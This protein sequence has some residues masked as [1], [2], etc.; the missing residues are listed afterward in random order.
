MKNIGRSALML[1]ATAAMLGCTETRF[2]DATGK[3]IIHGINGVVDAA[4]AI[5]LIEE[6]S[7]G[8]IPYKSA[9][10]PAEY[11]NLSYT[12]NFDLPIPLEDD[13]RIA[14][15]SVD[16]VEDTDYTFVLA[17][18]S[19]SAAEIVLWE[20]PVREWAGTET[21][22]EVG[23]GHVNNTLGAVDVYFA[24]PGTP[25]AAGNAVGA[26][27]FGEH[28]VDSEFAAGD[29]ELILTARD[30][31]S[32][33]VYSSTTVSLGAA[34]SYTFAV[35]DADPSITA[36]VSVR[37]ISLGGT[38]FEISDSRFPPTAQ[39]VHAGFGSGNI[40]IVVD[41]DF[42]NPLVTNLAFGAVSGDVDVPIGSST[43]AYV[44]TGNTMPLVEAQASFAGGSRSMIVVQGEAGSLSTLQLPSVRRGLST[45]S[46]LQFTNASFNATSVDY[47]STDPGVSVDDALPSLVD[48]SF[49]LSTGILSQFPKDAEIT[50]TANGDKTPL[51]GP[52]A[53]SFATG[54]VTEIVLLDTA[55]P[56]ASEL[57]IFS[58]LP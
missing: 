13:R 28:I 14:R 38:T 45:V 55:D 5:F 42:A 9:T 40:D 32:T 57:L 56:N 37:L 43:F 50:V 52:V 11:D 20:R 7:L 54:E 10:A 22:V 4:D 58:N 47:Y 35:F 36:T 19:T 26:L 31:P 16:V 46:R 27:D 51:A 3:G 29:Y 41:G 24:P 23:F 34:D 44:P 21:V 49:G 39:F 18:P 12:F 25:P 1:L 33:I 53:V 6:F 8:Q 48:V 17:G 15:L 2:E 30:D